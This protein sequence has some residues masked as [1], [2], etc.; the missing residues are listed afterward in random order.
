M[1]PDTLANA[2]TPNPKVYTSGP[3]VCK[4]ETIPSS[5]VESMKCHKRLTFTEL[6][7]QHCFVL[8]NSLFRV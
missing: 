4:T 7:N 8:N 6:C 1:A 2:L 5:T 3:W